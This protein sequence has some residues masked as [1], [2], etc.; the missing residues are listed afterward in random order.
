M[1]DEDDHRK[2]IFCAIISRRETLITRPRAPMREVAK[3]FYEGIWALLLPVIGAAAPPCD[4]PLE[5]YLHQQVGRPWD[6]VYAEICAGID[7][8]STAWAAG[9]AVLPMSMRP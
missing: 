7:R 8:R 9:G 1:C 5:R 4:A 6:A 3:A 2:D